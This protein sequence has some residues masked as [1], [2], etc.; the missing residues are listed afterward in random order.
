MK[1]TTLQAVLG[2]TVV[3]LSASPSLARGHHHLPHVERS[4]EHRHVR[5][6]DHASAPVPIK[7]RGGSCAFPTN[8]PNMVAVTPD[9]KNAGWA[10]SP[11]QSCEPGHYCPFACKPG[12]VMAQWDPDSTYDYPA[13]MVGFV[14]MLSS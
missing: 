13:S 11:D 7:K 12:M 6:I 10:M 14:F 3:L 8:D 9:E 4:I 5:L 2:A 1:F